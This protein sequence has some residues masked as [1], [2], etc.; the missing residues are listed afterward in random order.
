MLESVK[1]DKALG[2]APVFKPLKPG[3]RSRSKLDVRV[4]NG[5]DKIRIVCFEPL[6]PDDQTVFFSILALCTN[7]QRGLI[8]GVDPS[9]SD[10]HHLR[11]ELFKGQ[12]SD[13]ES[14]MVEA[15]EYELLT[16][17]GK[18]D[19]RENYRHLR[20]TLLRL[21]SVTLHIK[22]P[23]EQYP[24]RLLASHVDTKT[25]HVKIAVNNRSAAAILGNQ[26]AYIS[27]AE[28]IRLSY[29]PAKI[30]HGWLSSWLPQGA[31]RRITAGK[32]VTHIYSN[33]DYVSGASQRTYRSNA[34]RA[35][36]AIADELGWR[37]DFQG[38]GADA[39]YTIGRPTKP[40]Q[41]LS[42]RPDP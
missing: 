41:Q 24:V 14:I 38:R 21:S 4:E 33:Y 36:I 2:L 18:S 10:G 5:S 26:Y 15:S 19:G 32:L 35:A 9:S 23:T 8:L 27:L 16:M 20:E 12:A 22:T 7:D 28:H 30:L 6:G 31:E 25:R 42:A 29:E 39:M 37:V 13:R 17:C 40:I 1:H 34:K 3:E 11:N